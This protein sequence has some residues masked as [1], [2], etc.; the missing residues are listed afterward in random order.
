MHLMYAVHNGYESFLTCDQ[1]ILRRRDNLR[2]VCG[3]IR[4]QRPSE[5]AIELYVDEGR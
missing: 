5:L 1:G 4:I 2:N 3:S